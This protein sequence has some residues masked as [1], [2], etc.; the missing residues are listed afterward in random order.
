MNA[1]TYLS[2]KRIL[3]TGGSSGLGRA[4]AIASA[5]AGAK[6]AVVARGRGGL[7]E[8]SQ[9]P[10]IFPIV[11]DVADKNAVYRISGEAV[12]VLGGVDILVNNASSLG[13]TPL[14]QLLD[15]DCEALSEVLATNLVGPF[16]LTKAVLPAMLLHGGGL[17]VNISSDAA[18]SA[19]PTWGI[20]SA[21]KSALD[22]M[23]RIWNEE[24]AERGIRFLAVDP[25]DMD[26]PLHSAAIPD[27]DPADLLVPSDV[28]D[29]LLSLIGREID[30]S[31]VRHSASQWRA[32]L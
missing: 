10:N 11:A 29:D 15:T 4:L 20:Y 12:Q 7:E 31:I 16:R 5:K 18:V 13:P 26:T 21:S 27:A 6:V 17:V 19:Y 14:R 2:G 30:N 32:L 22:H 25:G 3:I 23:S 9:H 24:L 1:H 28:A 8:V